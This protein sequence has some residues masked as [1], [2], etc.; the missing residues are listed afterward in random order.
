VETILWD[1]DKFM[2]DLM[3]DTKGYVVGSGN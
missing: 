1:A 2:L 3:E